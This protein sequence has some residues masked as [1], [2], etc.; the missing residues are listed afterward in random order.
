VT[1]ILGQAWV[2]PALFPEE[3]RNYVKRV[4]KILTALEIP[5]DIV[6][7]PGRGYSLELRE[8]R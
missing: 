6:N 7:R 5:C 3:V 2:E 4:R 1:Q 8:N